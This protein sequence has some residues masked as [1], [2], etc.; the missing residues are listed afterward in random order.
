MEW[1][2]EMSKDDRTIDS[3][4]WNFPNKEPTKDYKNHPY[5]ISLKF[6][7]LELKMVTFHKF[8]LKI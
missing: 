2:L 8:H 5:I 6:S 7:S 4:F 1:S 3:K